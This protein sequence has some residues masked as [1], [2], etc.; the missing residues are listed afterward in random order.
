MTRRKASTRVDSTVIAKTLFDSYAREVTETVAAGEVY[1]AALRAQQAEEPLSTRVDSPVVQTEPTLFEEAYR[2]RTREPL[3]T[4]TVI[5]VDTSEDGDCTVV[6]KHYADGR[7]DIVSVDY[8]QPRPERVSSTSH[9][10][11]RVTTVSFPTTQLLEISDASDVKELLGSPI[12][13]LR[14]TL[15]ASER[16]SWDGAGA[17]DELRRKGARA[18]LL[19]PVVV[20]DEGKLSEVAR[21]DS[22]EAA[23]DAWFAALPGTDPADVEAARQTA[24]EYLE[25]ER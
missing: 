13:K 16:A 7:V 6:A 18:V 24:R 14:P 8:T 4:R 21:A 2:T 20:P 10:G 9:R 19:S 15:R 5:G 11:V 17:A 25:Q 1:R 23:I 12:V 3:P 22:P